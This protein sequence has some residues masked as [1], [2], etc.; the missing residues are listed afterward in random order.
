MRHIQPQDIHAGPDKLLEPFFA[1]RRR[2]K[3]GN[4]FGMPVVS[5]HILQYP[6][7]LFVEFNRAVIGVDIVGQQQ[8]L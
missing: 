2:A 7:Q 1:F 8:G 5:S 3:R 6:L 4:D